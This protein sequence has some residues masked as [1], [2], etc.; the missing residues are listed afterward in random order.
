MRQE[1]KKSSLENLNER[2]KSF[3][4]FENVQEGM[5]KKVPTTN[6]QGRKKKRKF[7]FQYQKSFF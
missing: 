2:R 1:R 3:E 4:R 6:E 7:H 5:K